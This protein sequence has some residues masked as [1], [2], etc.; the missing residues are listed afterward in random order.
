MKPF[1]FRG[2]KK[3]IGKKLIRTSPCK[4][5]MIFLIRGKSTPFEGKNN[6]RGKECPEQQGVFPSKFIYIKRH[7]LLSGENSMNKVAPKKECEQRV[8]DF[9]KEPTSG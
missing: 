6:L 9:E 5:N 7:H 2:E 8:P 1:V 3:D 4:E